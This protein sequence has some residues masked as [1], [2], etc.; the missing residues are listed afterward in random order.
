[1]ALTLLLY[2]ACEEVIKG[3]CDYANKQY[4]AEL[5][6]QLKKIRLLYERGKLSKKKYKKLEAQLT[7]AI[8]NFRV[9]QLKTGRRQ[10]DLNLI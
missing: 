3:V 2:K 1:L 5:E 8:K 9:Q 7:T 4:L 6:D 10:I